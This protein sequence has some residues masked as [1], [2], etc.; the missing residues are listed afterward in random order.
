MVQTV[1]FVPIDQA[2]TNEN[3][4]LRREI[5]ISDMRK[6][7]RKTPFGNDYYYKSLKWPVNAAPKRVYNTII[8]YTRG[9]L[10]YNGIL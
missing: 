6:T 5:C 3:W 7:N 1:N 4:G 9:L 8:V 10:Y 2:L